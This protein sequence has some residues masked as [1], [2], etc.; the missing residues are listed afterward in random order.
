ML[1]AKVVMDGNSQAVRIP[2][3]FRLN[4]REV[5]IE[6]LPDGSLLIKEKR[7]LPAGC[8]NIFEPFQGRMPDAY[9]GDPAN[10]RGLRCRASRQQRIGSGLS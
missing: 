9:G 6:R 1:S 5:W 2:K 3:A 7:P 10:F 4:S 8:S